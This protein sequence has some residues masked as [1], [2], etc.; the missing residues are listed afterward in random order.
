MSAK[1]MTTSSCFELKAYGLFSSLISIIGLGANF[2]ILV[3][4]ILLKEL[5]SH[6]NI[7]LFSLTL[8]NILGCSIDMP[9]IAYSCLS[10]KYKNAIL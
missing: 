3:M 5:K 9:V 8:A 1:N 6:K 7:F 4:Y 2:Y 10:C